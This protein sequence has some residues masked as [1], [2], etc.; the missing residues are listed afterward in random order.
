MDDYE[1]MRE[2]V[3]RRYSRV[4]NEDLPR[5]D[6]IL[7]DGGKGQLNAALKVLSTLGLNHIPIAGLAKKE[8]ELFLPERETP[9][10]LSRDS[11]ALKLLQAVRD[12]SHRFATGFHKKLRRKKATISVLEKFE[13]IGKAKARRLLT[14]FGSLQ[15]IASVPAEELA[16]V[17]RI[18]RQKAEN[19]LQGLKAELRN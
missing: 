19:L 2:V 12:E 16:R 8:E 7:I 15:A 5:P 18:N 6:L 17:A 9:L 13:G 1:A 11:L 4:L 3:A 10:V 14:M